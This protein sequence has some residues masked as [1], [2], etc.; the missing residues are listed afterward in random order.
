MF[1]RTASFDQL[2]Y[3]T[4]LQKQMGF[5]QQFK[6]DLFRT[7]D[8]DFLEKSL[9]L[10]RFQ[11]ENNTLYRNFVNALNINPEDVRS[12]EQIPFL[13]ISFF[14]NF[15]ITSSKTKPQDFFESSGTTGIIRSKLYYSD[16]DFYLR[17]TVDIF[18]KVYG[19]LFQ[20]SFFFL[21]PNY[22]ERQ[23]S[24]LVAMANHFYDLSDK[25]FGGFYLDDIVGLKEGLN[26]AYII[27]PDK[28]ILWGVTFALL[29]FANSNTVDFTGITIFETGGM[30]GRGKEPLRSEVHA[31]LSEKFQTNK[32][33]SEYGMTELFSQ[34]YTKEQSEIFKCPNQMQILIR[35]PEDPRSVHFRKGERGGVNIIDLANI[36]SCAF[37]ETQDLGVL[38]NDGFQI[39]GRFDNSEVRGCN[40]L[41][42]SI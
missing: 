18:E 17:N 20:Y 11:F 14:K 24:S 5:V 26:S 2:A 3:L 16:K 42:L 30:K 1:A 32:I 21:L 29:D 23:N 34:A 10:F 4:K 31:L 8:R 38:T 40:L 12:L 7:S 19:S 28:T 33:Y 41:V 22:L 39:L 6:S 15:I 35:E 13:P 9:A 37:I 36:D 27:K 25:S